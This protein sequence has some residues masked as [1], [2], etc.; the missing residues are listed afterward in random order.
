MGNKRENFGKWSIKD[1]L[2]LTIWNDTFY[3]FN[4]INTADTTFHLTDTLYFICHKISD[5]LICLTRNMGNEFQNEYYSKMP[6][7]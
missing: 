5:T 3:A 2:L 7:K 6:E 1:S 4:P